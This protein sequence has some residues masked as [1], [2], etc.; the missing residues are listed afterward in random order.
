MD[1]DCLKR[2]LSLEGY[3]QH[4]TTSYSSLHSFDFSTLCAGGD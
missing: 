3:K 2:E 4:M 1:R